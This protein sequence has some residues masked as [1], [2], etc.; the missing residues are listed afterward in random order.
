MSD[1]RHHLQNE[2]QLRRRRSDRL[3]THGPDGAL[4]PERRGQDR[5][6]RPV[7]VTTL[8]S[9]DYYVTGQPGE[10]IV[11]ILGS[12]V[13]ACM[14]DPVARVGGMNHFLLPEAAPSVDTSDPQESTRYG[15][16]AMEQ[17]INGILKLGGV[18]KRLEVK[19]FGGANVTSSSA[20]I[21]SK[22]VAFVK[23]FLRKEGLSIDSSDLGEDYPRR[24]RYYPDTGKVMLLKLRRRADMAVVDEEKK[25]AESLK[26]KPVEG[27]IELF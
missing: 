12:C 18:K 27:G 14:H 16:F 20:M 10:M 6:D 7:K 11:T 15:A 5:D 2:Q 1:Q 3:S 8:Y 23:E 17:L 22:N 26:N 9:G 4:I 19:V 25:F 21:G 24:L 13:A